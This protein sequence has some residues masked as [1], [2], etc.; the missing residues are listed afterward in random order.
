MKMRGATASLAMA[1]VAAVVTALFGTAAAAGTSSGAANAHSSISQ[2][3][4]TL[5]NL[6]RSIEDNGRDA[7]NLFGKRQ[8]W[9]DNNLRD[10]EADVQASSTSLADM[11]AQLTETEAA[12]D[13][14]EGTVQQVKVDIEM[15]Q[16]TI[17]QTEDMLKERSGD[18]EKK[19]EAD[20]L[21]SLVENKQLSLASLQ[22]E[23]EVAVPVLA[24][25]QANV[26]ETKQRISYR[27]ETLQTSKDFIVVLKDSC[28]GSAHRA[29]TQA[30][31]RIGESN[32][33]HVALQA[34]EGSAQDKESK[35]D[36]LLD[37]PA[38]QA[39]SFVQVSDRSQEVT[40][41]DLSD[42]FEADQEAHPGTYSAPVQASASR[43]VED[44]PP[45]PP[46][47]RPRIQTLLAQL[48]NDDGQA[49]S[50]DQKQ[51]CTKQRESSAMALKF[52]K[53][54]VAQIGSELESHIDAEAELGD[55]L[56]KLKT[57][58]A[59]VTAV[60]KT[61]L[62]QAKKEKSLLE[63]SK[64]DQQLA[65]KILDQAMTILEELGASKADKSV[66][67][68]ESAKK[69]LFAQIKAADGFENEAQ[70]KA[71]VVAERTLSLTKN[72]E[73]EQHNLE[74]AKDDHASLRL[75]GVENQRLY[76]ADV[77]EATA[78][79]QKLE[80]SCSADAMEK[81]TQ[82]RMAQEHALEDADKALDGK[83]EEAK[84]P[85]N[86]LRGGSSG[87]G[88]TAADASKPKDMTPMQRAA[89]EMGVSMD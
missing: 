83:L 23:L 55:E 81:A 6:L 11:Q 76:Q 59:S 57:T 22:G 86:V 66:V 73:D 13:E 7:E 14:A 74:F 60:A 19:G 28:E 8:L 43:V 75:R 12:V 29:D 54:S 9:C 38:A 89:M 63:S 62:E 52:A 25:L 58:S 64:K 45:P 72:Q 84:K 70:A 21:A 36:D 39:L 80:D 42:L 53:D 27:T 51:W 37:S 34:L 40:A 20:L 77:E 33:I 2:I 85:S 61:A 18:A 5:Q 78:Y 1:P 71:K 16:H 41:D 68:L 56:D 15:V 4:D 69:M 82:Q 47:V 30:A 48:K 50:A 24:Q 67:G 87:T 3:R 17:K 46:S 32:S 88:A 65:T 49:T 26:A 35:D 10:F 31:A 79:A 44:A